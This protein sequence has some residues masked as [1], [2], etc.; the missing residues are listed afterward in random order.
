MQDC[1]RLSA[2]LV[3][4]FVENQFPAALKLPEIAMLPIVGNVSLEEGEGV[5][6]TR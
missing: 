4:V 3:P 6:P 2:H 1:G 5:P